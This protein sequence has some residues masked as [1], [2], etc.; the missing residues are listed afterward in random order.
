MGKA[1]VDVKPA[2]GKLG[3]LMPGMGAVATTFMAGVIAARRG[4]AK[5][6]GSLTQMGTVRIG[7]RS[8]NNSPKIQDYI[9]IANMKDI[10]FGGWDIFP[11][12]AYEAALRAGVLEKSLLSEL[13]EELSAI[14][15]MKAVFEQ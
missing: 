8:D 5:P 3:I 1:R 4:I 12:N 2:T 7:K 15:P 11:D 13:K 9:P 14:K 10:A 6:I